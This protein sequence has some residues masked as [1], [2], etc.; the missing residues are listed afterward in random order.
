NKTAKP[1]QSLSCNRA[2]KPRYATRGLQL[3]LATHAGCPIQARFWL[4]WDA[5]TVTISF[6]RQ[7]GVLSKEN[8]AAV[9]PPA[10]N[11]YPSLS[12]YGGQKANS[13]GRRPG[14]FPSRDGRLVS[15]R[16]RAADLPSAARLAGD[17][18]WRK[19]PD[20]RPHRHRQDP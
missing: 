10:P 19:H 4:E 13:N 11:S 12:T 14:P 8:G 1:R 7:S 2:K 9:Q 17:R 3:L 18:P 15:R 20:S 6:W 5:R 16:L